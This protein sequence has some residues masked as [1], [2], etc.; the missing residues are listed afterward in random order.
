[1][2]LTDGGQCNH[3]APQTSQEAVSEEPSPTSDAG[4][5]TPT[6]SGH[7]NDFVLYDSSP[8]SEQGLTEDALFLELEKMD[9]ITQVNSLL[10]DRFQLLTYS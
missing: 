7:G 1:M 4:P 3:V 10:L 6:P 2:I 9:A 5:V 8:G